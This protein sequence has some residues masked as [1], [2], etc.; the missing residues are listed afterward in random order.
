MILFVAIGFV[1]ILGIGFFGLLRD[2]RLAAE[3]H[4]LMMEFRGRFIKF[5]IE[6]FEKEELNS[7]EYQ[8]LL[9]NVDEISSLL[10][11]ADTMSYRPAYAN[12]VINNYQ[13]LINLLP[14]FNSSMG[15]HRD[16]A[17]SADSILTR[18]VGS[19]GKRIAEQRKRLR[20]PINWLLEGVTILLSIPLLLLKQFGILS[21]N[22]YNTARNS[23]ILRFISGIVALV[24]TIDTVY[25]IL[26]R[27]SFTVELATQAI[28]KILN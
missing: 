18:Y 12:Y 3:K 22:A 28:E 20:N 16:D 8:W 7:K 19:L 10:G 6:Y 11:G 26:T 13:L 27:N 23:G 1:L 2:I 15:A 25:I 4:E 14:S 24:S 9:E 5:A 17:T 21:K